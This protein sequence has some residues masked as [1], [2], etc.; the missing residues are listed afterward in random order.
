MKPL[1]D[2]IR[3]DGKLYND[4][5]DNKHK[6]LIEGLI[7]KL[8]H[9]EN[10]MLKHPNASITLKESGNVFI[11]SYPPDLAERISKAM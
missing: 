9:L 1:Y 4:L 3:Y 11:D 8:N 5:I 10:E 7:G 2:V 6:R